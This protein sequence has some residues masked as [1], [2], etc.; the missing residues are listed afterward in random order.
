MIITFQAIYVDMKR[1]TFEPPGYVA[2]MKLSPRYTGTSIIEIEGKFDDCAEA[3]SRQR[4]RFE[5]MLSDFTPLQWAAPSRCDG[6]SMH[7]VV[8]H[9]VG[10]NSFWA[11]SVGAGVLGAPTQLLDNFDP[12]ATP[13]LIVE[14][15]RSLPTQELLAQF[16]A[17]NAQFLDALAS[18][19]ET[20]WA[21]IAE[22]PPGHVSIRL[23]AHHALWDSW[24]HERDVA[25]PL[26]IGPEVHPDEIATCLRYAAAISP[27]LAL[28]NSFVKPGTFTL[29]AHSPEVTFTLDVGNAV[30]ITNG[31]SDSST[32]ALEGHA[33]ELIEALSLRVPL[34]SSAPDDWRELLGG[35]AIAFDSL[36]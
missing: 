25:L 23:L 28:G 24:I 13:P 35:L 34:P 33:I 22:A 36:R 2:D 5:A 29:R 30:M 26:G 6:W 4:R 8:A 31:A 15:M 9:L 18:L 11:M 12:A 32:V 14:P 10:V 21:A 17:T 7:D 16:V 19:T 20:E 27:A 1:V 3:V